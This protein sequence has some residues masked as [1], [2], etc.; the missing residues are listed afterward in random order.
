M[1]LASQHRAER[2]GR[3]AKTGLRRRRERERVVWW[4]T[5]V[6]LAI[7]LLFAAV[8][9]RVQV[10][11]ELRLRD[12]LV[13]ERERL[14]RAV[15]ELAGERTRLS[16]WASIGGRARGIGLRPPRTS[17]V[18]WVRVGNERGG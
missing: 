10:G 12:D 13:A 17:E 8:W 15:G 5:A 11:D 2:A 3:A 9:F 18:L 16:T 6:L 1:I 14:E 7:P 4:A